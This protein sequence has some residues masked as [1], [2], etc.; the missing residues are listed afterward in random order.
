MEQTVNSEVWADEK[1]CGLGQNAVPVLIKLKDPH[2]FPHQKQ[3]PLKPEIKEGLK[4]ITENLKDQGQLIPCNS[5]CNTP[6]LGVKKSS[7]E[8]RLIQDL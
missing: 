1:N 3:Y 7:D 6:I 2:L 8:W 5:P 4:P